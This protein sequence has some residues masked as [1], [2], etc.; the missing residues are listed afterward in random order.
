VIEFFE[1]NLFLSITLAIVATAT[2]LNAIVTYLH[3]SRPHR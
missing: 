1:S 3:I 2:L